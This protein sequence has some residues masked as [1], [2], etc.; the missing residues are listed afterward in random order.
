MAKKEN[1]TCVPATNVTLDMGFEF[2]DYRSVLV[3]FRYK[4]EG[5]TGWTDT[6]WVEQNG[7]GTH[8][9]AEQITYLSPNTTYYYMAML[10]Y[11]G[12]AV[13]GT[14]RSFTTCREPIPPTVVTGN[15][16]SVSA[17]TATLNMRYEF[18]DYSPVQVQFRYKAEGAS[19][20]TDTDLV[21]Q[22]GSDDHT[23]AEQI[24]Y[25]S[26]N[27]TYYYMAML[28]Y[29][30]MEVNSSV[31]PFT[32]CRESKPP[33]VSTEKATNVSVATAT[34]NMAYEFNDY[35]PVQIQF[36][37]KAKGASAWSDTGWVTRN[38]SGA[39]TYAEPIANLSY[40]TTYYF[41]ALFKYD[42]MVIEGAEKSFTTF[43]LPEVH[44]KTATNI[45]DSAAR[46]NMTFDFKDY[47]TVQVQ[48]R[49]KAEGAS[50]W[51]ETERASKNGSG[52]RWYSEPIADLSSDTTYYFKAMLLYDSTE[53]NG[54]TL[55]FTTSRRS[56]PPTVVTGN[57]TNVS[58]TTATLN[59]RYEFLDYSPV[60]VR[61]RYKAEGAS[62]WNETG[63]VSKNGSG[64]RRYREPIAD[65]ST[66]T[67]YY[68]MAKLMYD[69]TVIEGEE[70]SFM[71]L[72][73]PTVRTG[74]ATN[75]TYASARLNMTCELNDY[76]TVQVQFKYKAEGAK[77]K[78]FMT[79]EPPAVHTKTATNITDATATLNTAFNFND[80]NSVQV[81]FRY[82]PEGASVWN[83]TGWVTQ[84]GS[85][86]HWY[87]ESSAGLSSGT[88][89]Q[90]EALLRYD[91]TIIEGQKRSFITMEKPTVSTKKAIVQ[92]LSRA[93]A[94]TLR[95]DYE[96]NDY[97]HGYVRFAYKKVGDADWDHTDWISAS[98]SGTYDESIMGLEDHTTYY[99]YA[100]LKY[101]DENII[102]GY[103]L[104]F[105]T[106]M[107]R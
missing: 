13:N 94:A 93:W 67:T 4:A 52:F 65:L 64:F 79:L 45:S 68:F 87:S 32:T 63:W 66:N 19:A 39:H 27:T 53:L 37:Y 38:G 20:W 9:Y 58:A 33:T 48:F 41:R 50:V 74:N 60:N 86:F 100:Q 70:K 99:T 40:V 62:V 15:A 17:T 47:R 49:Y 24:T 92:K 97:D 35:S 28:L 95:M 89:Y 3:Q 88:V 56:M 25:L 26:P 83:E 61:F 6:G 14:V 11:D 29:D 96:F 54:T 101:G 36:R 5:A 78:S 73:P 43:E 23:Y 106:L 21:S 91:G 16:T 30:R 103:T 59:M 10:L 80:Y 82:K 107:P 72:E 57:A 2:H 46:L 77:E 31:H 84:N 12:M 85:G 90:F 34:L 22:N 102:Q 7:S 55:S 76:D 105:K 51:N 1:A 71:T 42:S 98:H 75:I 8:M 81:Q 44:T 104:T 69:S 18:N